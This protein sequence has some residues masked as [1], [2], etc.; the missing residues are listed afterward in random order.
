[1]REEDGR[2][3]PIASPEVLGAIRHGELREPLAA[4]YPRLAASGVPAV[5]LAVASGDAIAAALRRFESAVPQA[6]VV[7]RSDAIHDLVSFDPPAVAA[8]V[9]EALRATAAAGRA[10]R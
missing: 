9:A 6:K 1:M 5:L 7:H 4:I 8:A 2:I 3:R 10:S